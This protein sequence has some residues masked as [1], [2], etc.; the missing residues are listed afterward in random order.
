MTRPTGRVRARVGALMWA[1]LA[2]FVIG[3]A[4]GT[5][6]TTFPAIGTTPQPAGDQTAAATRTVVDALAAQGLQALESS[7]SYRPA[8]GALLAA[9]PR[10]LLQVTL[11]ND[12]THG[13]ILVY[14][15]GSAEA[16]TAAANDQAAYLST[17]VAK[18]YYPPGTAFV[19][20]V[21]G[22]NVV[23]YSWL[24]ANAPDPRTPQIQPVL[25]TVGT[26]VQVPG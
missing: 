21:V 19:L 10:T 24:P 7:G 12:P 16:A 3:C 6:R 17:S 25:E 8:E 15:L 5:P 18:A 13:Y 2:V 11:P 20:R 14:A 26:E 22:S 4:A 1:S 9:A 23:F